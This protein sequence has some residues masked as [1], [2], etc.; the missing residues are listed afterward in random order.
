MTMGLTNCVWDGDGRT[1]PGA[2]LLLLIGHT[3]NT[4]NIPLLQTPKL[5]NVN[6]IKKIDK[7]RQ[8]N[9]QAL[10]WTENEYITFADT[11]IWLTKPRLN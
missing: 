9:W 4:G 3:G 1:L 5:R 10:L 7:L 8:Q 11:S 6:V 2:G